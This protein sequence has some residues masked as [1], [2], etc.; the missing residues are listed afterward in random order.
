MLNDIPPAECEGCHQPSDDLENV[1]LYE[2][3]LEGDEYWLCSNC[4]ITREMER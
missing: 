3:E 2:P 1:A 4:V